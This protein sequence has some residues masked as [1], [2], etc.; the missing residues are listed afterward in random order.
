M[1]A[2][3][4]WRP[5]IGDP[6]WIGWI[7]VVAYLISVLLCVRAGLRAREKSSGLKNESA[8]M[9]FVFA[10]GLLL[11]GVNKQLDLQTA[12][13]ELGGQL[14]RG[15]GWYQKRRLAQIIFV[16][17]LGAA[18]AGAALIMISKQRIFFKDH[19]FALLG[20]IF[21]A[22]FLL[23]RAAIFNH[24]DDDAGMGLGEGQ[25]LDVLELAGI[26][27]FI[28]ASFRAAKNSIRKG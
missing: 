27:C 23:M 21:L 7:T 18:M 2:E 28:V 17:V 16:A 20:G 19:A 9:W 13:I 3:I 1:M 12:F 4:T 8:R 6:T 22:A 15:E 11:L 14:A 24:V 10:V 25:W 5:E 26:F